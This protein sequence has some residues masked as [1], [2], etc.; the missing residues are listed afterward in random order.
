MKRYCIGVLLFLVVFL[1]ADICFAK[2]E[3]FKIEV[4][5][6]TD[7]EPFEQVYRGF[8]E[9]LSAAGIVE[10]KNLEINRRIIDFNMEKG[11]LWKKLGVLMEIRKE[12]SRIA[13]ARPDLAMTI[14]TPATKYAK[15]KIISAGIPLVFSAVLIPEVAGCKSLSVAGHGFTGATMHMD[16]ASVLKIARFAFPDIKTIGIVHTDDDN[17]LA[18]V[19]QLKAAGPQAGFTFIVREISKNDKFTPAATELIAQGAE[20]FAVPLDTYY[21]LRNYEPCVELSNVSLKNKMPVL[22]LAHMNVPGALLYIG[23]EFPLTGALAGKQAAKILLEGAEPGSL[24]ILKQDD[25]TVIVDTDM[26][27]SLQIELPMEILMLAKGME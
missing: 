16:M 23:A 14:A 17:T 24:P 10:G 25:L 21:A 19:E 20:A 8:L 3:T 7:I 9:E 27:K 26:L 13:D 15:D 22:S 6:V 4:L 2:Q 5:Q 11:G 18:Q 1:M 12:A